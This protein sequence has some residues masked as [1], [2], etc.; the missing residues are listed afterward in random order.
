VNITDKFWTVPVKNLLSKILLCV[1][2]E[3]CVGARVQAQGDLDQRVGKEID[4]L[5]TT[6]KHIHQNPE[7]S[8]EEKET[9][10]LLANELRQL[11]FAVSER[12]GQ[13]DSPGKVSYGVVGVLKNGPG[14]TVM[15]RTEL[16]ALPV[17]ERTGLP[18]A[19]HVKAKQVDGEVS[20]MHACG[21]D[22]HMSVWI[23]TA[24]LLAESKKEWSGTVVM[25]GQPSEE[26]G[27]GANAMLHDG[28]YSKFPRPDFVIALHDNPTVAAGKVAWK[29]G[30]MLASADSVDILVRGYGG[31]GA[32]PHMTK[33]PIVIASEIVIMLQTI[34][35]R[36]VDPFDSAVV[37]VGSFHAG[38]KGN[39]IPDEARL[40]LTVRTL[41]PEVREKVLAS[42]KRIA[43]NVAAAAGVPA[44]RAPVVKVVH[45][46]AP[47]T[48]NPELSRRVGAAL[49]RALGK[50]NVLPA[51]AIMASEDFSEYG[52]TDAKVPYCMF[53]LGATNPKRLAE[54]R[55]KRLRLPGL[56]SSEFYPEPEPAIRTGVKGMTASVMELLTK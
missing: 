52:L 19:S 18:Y 38:T 42:I 50:D 4:S 30:P 7:L 35:S 34:V 24:R 47:T 15:V 32:A 36:E 48:N 23:G 11:G 27:G 46:T 31:H 40:Q 2:A 43:E 14:P 51:E 1:L 53:W 16:D 56:H 5:T 26:A 39:I 22:L 41:K 33:D 55:E 49:E 45:S 6:Y 9:S 12:V 10:A 29:E 8:T 28:L 37:T 3:F 44:E 54:A 17:E 20:V 13:Y 21:H 25:I